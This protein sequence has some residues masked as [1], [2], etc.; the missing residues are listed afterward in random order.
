MIFIYESAMS[1]RHTTSSFVTD[2]QSVRSDASEVNQAV[3]HHYRPL[4]RERCIHAGK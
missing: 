2:S 4:S 1:D 3:T